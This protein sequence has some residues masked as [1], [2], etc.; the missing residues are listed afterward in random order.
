MVL[1]LLSVE[2]CFFN[3]NQISSNSGETFQI[4]EDGPIT[5]V[6]KT[7]GVFCC[8]NCAKAFWLEHKTNDKYVLAGM[9]LEQIWI[10]ETGKTGKRLEAALPRELLK[11]FGGSLDYEEYHNQNHSKQFNKIK[12]TH[13]AC[14]FNTFSTEIKI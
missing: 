1:S 8:L 11:C 7:Y 13:M 5:H 9:L 4:K 10:T 2:K 6:Y 3:T 12:M 14:I